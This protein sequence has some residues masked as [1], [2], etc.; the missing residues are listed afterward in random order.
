MLIKTV[1]FKSSFIASK[2]VI[3]NTM[4]SD[5]KAMNF[6]LTNVVNCLERRNQNFK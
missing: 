1:R 3:I 5:I 2:A 4:N 6:H